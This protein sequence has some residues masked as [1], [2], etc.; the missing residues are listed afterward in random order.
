MEIY[1]LRHSF[2]KAA[3]SFAVTCTLQRLSRKCFSTDLKKDAV[4]ASVHEDNFSLLF[5][6]CLMGDLKINLSLYIQPARTG[7]IIII[8]IANDSI[9]QFCKRVHGWMISKRGSSR[10]SPIWAHSAHSAHSTQLSLTR[11][12]LTSP[13]FVARDRCS[14][15]LH[16]HVDGCSKVL[17][18]INYPCVPYL[19]NGPWIQRYEWVEQRGNKV[20]LLVNIQPSKPNCWLCAI[21]ELPTAGC[22]MKCSQILK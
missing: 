10:W 21:F 2:G 18:H 20:P 17:L 12:P 1:I 16:T 19:V 22:R 14:R 5:V 6:Q 8:Q 13:L 3:L 4:G 9:C 11:P 7:S 15:G